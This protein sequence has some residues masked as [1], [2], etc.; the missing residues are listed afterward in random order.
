MSSFFLTDI[1]NW[2]SQKYFHTN[3]KNMNSYK[4]VLKQTLK[5]HGLEMDLDQS[6]NLSNY[7]TL[8]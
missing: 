8:L 4:E 3:T 2:L 6:Q 1:P 7:F 5:Q